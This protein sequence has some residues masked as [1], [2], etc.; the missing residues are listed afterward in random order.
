MCLWIFQNIFV[1]SFQWFLHTNKL[2]NVL[3]LH[4]SG[5][6]SSIR[7]N[8]WCLF[9][10]PSSL[11]RVSSL[12]IN[13]KVTKHKLVYSFLTTET[14]S[15]PILKLSQKGSSGGYLV[16]PP[17]QIRINTELR[18]GWLYKSDLEYL[19]GQ[20]AHN[21]FGQPEPVLQ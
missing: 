9:P 10:P 4:P 3:L 1:Y 11:N 12:L 16:Q 7:R 19:Q 6:Q 15:I 17:A 21:L 2:T 8:N 5:S 14:Y 13:S 18:L 20:K